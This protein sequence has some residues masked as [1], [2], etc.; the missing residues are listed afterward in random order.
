MEKS[1]TDR[2]KNNISEMKTLVEHGKKIPFSGNVK[3]DQVEFLQR[4][5]EIERMLVA[6]EKFER[7]II[8]SANERAE[9]IIADAENQKAIVLASLV[10]D[11]SIIPYMAELASEEHIK[12]VAH[13]LQKTL[14]DI[15]REKNNITHVLDISANKVES[16]RRELLKVSQGSSENKTL[17]SLS[18][19]EAA[20]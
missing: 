17:K 18:P 4:F 10:N 8:D 5:K 1:M 7:Q 13:M 9:M 19:K 14:T 6:V 12:L 2:I 16:Y 20:I 15:K 11:P 3:V